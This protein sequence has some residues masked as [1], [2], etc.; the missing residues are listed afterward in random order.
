ME[1]SRTG[2]LKRL[3]YACELAENRARHQPGSRSEYLRRWRSKNLE[4]V[5]VNK[6]AVQAQRRQVM[7]RRPPW[8]DRKQVRAFYAL[9][10]WFRARGIAAQVDHIVPLRSPLVC[11]LHVQTNLVVTTTELNRRKSNRSWPDAWE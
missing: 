2:R 8:Y 11:G 3:C 4:R 6:A 5:K 7:R 9:A 1:R 10:E